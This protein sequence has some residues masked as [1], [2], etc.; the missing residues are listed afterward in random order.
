[1]NLVPMG[2]SCAVF[3]IFIISVILL[4]PQS[5]TRN[6]QFYIQSQFFKQQTFK[7]LLSFASSKCTKKHQYINEFIH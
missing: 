4:N 2:I 7:I 1:M 6:P 3:Y 5:A